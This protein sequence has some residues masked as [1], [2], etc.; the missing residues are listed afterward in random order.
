MTKL[1]RIPSASGLRP[2]SEALLVHG[3]FWRNVLHKRKAVNLGRFLST[4]GL[5]PDPI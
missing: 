2:R 5:R 4:N 1:G 3:D